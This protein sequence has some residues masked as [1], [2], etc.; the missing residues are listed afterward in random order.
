MNIRVTAGRKGGR[1]RKG[2]PAGNSCLQIRTYVG[3]LK[4]NLVN[5]GGAVLAGMAGMHNMYCTVLASVGKHS[6][7]AKD[8]LPVEFLGSGNK[9]M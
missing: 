7:N 9:D 4:C 2:I 6:P 1:S 5:T 3:R 8:V